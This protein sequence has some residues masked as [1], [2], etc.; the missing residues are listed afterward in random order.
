MRLV[1]FHSC[2]AA[3]LLVFIANGSLRWLERR[4]AQN[5]RRARAEARA[6]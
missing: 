5:D 4:F 1:K 2:F 6:A 3:G